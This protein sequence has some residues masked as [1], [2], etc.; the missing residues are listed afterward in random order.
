MKSR[1]DRY[2]ALLLEANAR[3]NLTAVRE[4][5]E[6]RVRHF[7]D[8]LRL[9]EAEAF[10]GKRVLD[11]GSGA[12]FPGLVLKFAEPGV[13]LTLLDAT[14]K[15][16]RF[17]QSVCGALGL[18]GVAC[19]HGRAEELGHDTAF[20][21]RFDVV[22]ARGVAAL[23]ALCEVCLPFVRAG[24]VFLAMKETPENFS[25]AGRFGGAQEA[26]FLYTLSDGRSHAV[27]R[28][29]KTAPTPPEFPRTWAKI[30]NQPGS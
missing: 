25:G 1:L 17:L 11:V 20:R 29:R 9:L 23:P 28:F 15:K 26:P 13:R 14:G 18:S 6:I 3:F 4:P 5:E 19:V 27:C 21:E 2:L 16:V 10:A 12:G 22:T 8:S 24:G 30:K 7:E